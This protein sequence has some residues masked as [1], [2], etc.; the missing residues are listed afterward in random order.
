M[1]AQGYYYSHPCSDRTVEM[2]RV[3]ELD[4]SDEDHSDEDVHLLFLNV[5]GLRIWTIN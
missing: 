4:K 1:R 3:E 5:D 2:T